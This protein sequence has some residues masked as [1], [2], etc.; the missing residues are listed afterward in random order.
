MDVSATGPDVWLGKLGHFLI[1][2]AFV[3]A[4]VSAVLYYIGFT[5]SGVEERSY[6][7]TARSL[8]F[9][10]ALSVFSAVFLLFYM[11]AAKKYAFAY[12]YQHA[13][14]DLPFQYLFAAF[15]EGQEGSTLLWAFWHAVLG[16]VAVFASRKWEGSVVGTVAMVQAFLMSMV[17]GIFFFGYKVGISPFGLLKSTMSNA[18]IFAMDPNFIPKDG[19]GLNELLRNYWMV[20][21]PPT[22]FLG[23]AAMTIPFG[24]ALGAL[25]RRDLTGWIKPVMPWA[26][27]AAG[28]LGLGTL[29]GGAW[30]YE[31]LSFGGFWAW[32]PVENAVL[33]P[34]L[35]IVSAIHLLLIF[36]NTNYSGLAAFV[37]TILSFLLIVY[38]TF[39]TKSGVLGETSVHSFTDL[40]MS[41][42]LLIFLFFFWYL[43][44]VF[45]QKTRQNRLVFT[46]FSLASLLLY[47]VTGKAVVGLVAFLVLSLASLFFVRDF[48]KKQKEEAV[49]S[50]EFWMF[51]GALA[52]LLSG[53]H[54]S[55]V[56]SIPVYN[57]LM[58]TNF[59]IPEQSHYNSI[60][61]WV[62]LVI[63]ALSAIVLFMG[64]G[65]SKKDRLRKL[66]FP[67][68]LSAI[69]TVLVSVL[70]KF[71]SISYIL[72][73]LAS[74]FAVFANIQYIY[75]FLRGKIKIAGSSIAHIGFGLLLFGVVISQSK[76]E[77]LSL[78]DSGF[79]YNEEADD[80]FNEEN[81]LLYE[82]EGKPMGEYQVTLKGNN[83]GRLRDRVIVEFE[84]KNENWETEKSFILKPAFKRMNEE[85]LVADPAIRRTLTKDLFTHISLLN[86]GTDIDTT[87]Y[88]SI[89]FKIGDTLAFDRMLFVLNNV[90]EG[91]A[92][93][94]DTQILSDM[95]VI[96]KDAEYD[97]RPSF[98]IK[99]NQII[100]QSVDIPEEKLSLRLEKVNPE[101]ENFTV[102]IKSSKPFKKYIL[103]KAMFFPLINLVWLGSILMFIGFMISVVQRSKK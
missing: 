17:L 38:S 98:I 15:W 11:L 73:L 67:F 74:A 95:A 87:A 20:I 68:F 4:V 77:I 12:V 59:S 70:Y 52:L 85:D 101:Q 14:N 83:E 64:Y 24:Y 2:L 82:G 76:K 26:L 35:V 62:A 55:A 89:D 71:S 92:L 56:T 5:K 94:D 39:L 91:Q 102:G 34:W 103:L 58:D 21:H 44:F 32:D 13:S 7:R 88:E 41:G 3:T 49:L 99:D 57:R 43:G 50:R 93:G 53:M 23:F 22:V 84:K 48:P 86:L 36:K 63:S 90:Q 69:T 18:P 8:F 75:T 96:T 16:L 33:V 40:G 97:V 72:L 100:P 54:I 1:I 27:F 51:I 37:L 79:I 29:M 65:Q 60:Q 66:I 81:V 80:E 47:V 42:Q 10:H 46:A 61:L 6:I 25:R 19:N 45:L 9:L 78:N 31:S 30:A 28:V